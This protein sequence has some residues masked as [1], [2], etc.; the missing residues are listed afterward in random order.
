MKMRIHW[1][2]YQAVL[3][4]ELHKSSTKKGLALAAMESARR[5]ETLGFW[6]EPKPR[7]SQCS[8]LRRPILRRSLHGGV[9]HWAI[10]QAEV[11]G[12]L[13]PPDLYGEGQLAPDVL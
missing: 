2:L 13:D 8:A 7:D 9:Y 6:S 10:C 11:A 4:P 1:Q 5:I 3:N 12:R